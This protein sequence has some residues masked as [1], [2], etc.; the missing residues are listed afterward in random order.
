[1]YTDKTVTNWCNSL[2]D[3]DTEREEGIMSLE[4]LFRVATY[5]RDLFTGGKFCS[6][7]VRGNGVTN[8]KMR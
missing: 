7:R 4:H 8:I 6:Q 2:C 5:G 1:M 3:K